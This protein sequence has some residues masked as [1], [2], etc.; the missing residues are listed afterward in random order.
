[1]NRFDVAVVGGGPAGVAAALASAAAGA[2]T[3]LIERDAALGGN[4]T[5]ALVH[6]ICG[7]YP[8]DAG[9]SPRVLHPGLPARVAE[10]LQRSGGAGAPERAARVHYLPVRP[11]A[12]GA[13]VEAACSRARGLELRKATAL[14][15]VRLAKEPG[16]DSLL[17]LAG[18]SAAGPDAARAAIVVDT[19]GEAAVAALGGASTRLETSP[20][21]QR[22][23]FIFRLEGVEAEGLEGFARLQLSAAVARGARTGELPEGCES[24]VVRPDGAAGSLYATLTLPAVP[25]DSA[26]SG[27]EAL[28]KTGR[29]W[30]ERV[31]G[32]L[33]ETRPGFA[34]ARVADW[35]SRVGVRESA[36]LAGRLELSREHVLTGARLPDEVALSAWPIELWED[37]RRPQLELP[38]G[39]CSVPLGALVS[40]TH[41]GLA[42]AGRC[43][44][45]SHAA[46]GALRVVG[47]A[48]ATGEAAGVAAALAADAGSALHAVDA[49]RVRAR[50]AD[51]AG[52]YVLP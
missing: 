39:P 43:L 50:I 30:A 46:L 36:R 45:A 31:V 10:A 8:V 40:E 18:S 27:P 3:L 38:A 16:E 17:E 22:A 15:G 37:H 52:S 20:R 29:D 35:P 19:T 44:S 51:G 28:A 11:P 49:A 14:V 23:S 1:M 34:R 24:V 4:V 47:T 32:L 2:R 5:Q 26:G 41:P 7:L 42:T 25:G 48:L 21:R 9:E 6:T 13:L 33:R 12:F